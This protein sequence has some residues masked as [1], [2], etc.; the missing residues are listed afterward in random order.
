MFKDAATSKISS[1]F[2]V[3]PKSIDTLEPTASNQDVITGPEYRMRKRNQ[4]SLNAWDSKKYSQVV[5]I[6]KDLESE[7]N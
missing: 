5:I 2:I 3:S 7:D 1:L 4:D 6:D